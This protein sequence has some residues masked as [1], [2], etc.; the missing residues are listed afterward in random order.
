MRFVQEHTIANKNLM[1]STDSNIQR[2][3]QQNLMETAADPV[4]AK[5]FILERGMLNCVRESLLVE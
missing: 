3:R 5:A 2:Q 4:K 1:E